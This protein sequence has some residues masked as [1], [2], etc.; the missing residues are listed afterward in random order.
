MNLFARIISLASNPLIISVP[1]SYSLVF[2]TSEDF[3]YAAFWTLISLIFAAIV[4]VFVFYG[5]R[6]GLFSDFDISK[7]EERAPIFAFTGIIS[8]VYFIL[9]YILSGPRIL[10]VA[11]GALLLGVMLES[12]INRKIKASIH[13]AAFSS[14]SFVVGILYGG[15]FWIALLLTP[16][17][18]WS[19]I[20]LKKHVLQETI[21][22]AILGVFLVIV[23]YFVIKYFYHYA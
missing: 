16:L 21:I 18:A 9:I 22:G 6:I 15:I 12:F 7:K 20:K 8:F 3:Y 17:I 1:M 4:G 23:L 13:L 14:F 11:L 5:V 19:R 10:L 2:K